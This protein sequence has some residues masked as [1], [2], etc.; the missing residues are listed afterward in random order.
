MKCVPVPHI[1]FASQRYTHTTHMHMLLWL[2]LPLLLQHNRA[3]ILA[4]IKWKYTIIKFSGKKSP[5]N[6]VCITLKTVKM[7]HTGNHMRIKA[8]HDVYNTHRHS[9]RERWE[10]M[11][12]CRLLY[13]GS[14]MW[15][16]GGVYA[17]CMCVVSEC[18]IVRRY[19]YW[20]PIAYYGNATS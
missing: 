12:I 10:H 19:G 17:E 6:S 1:C 14:W 7:L 5:K 20:K 16:A 8:T 15:D 3:A 9:L 4:Y 18:A 2:P 11:Y 13:V